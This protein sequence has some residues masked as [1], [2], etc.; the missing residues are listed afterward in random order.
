VIDFSLYLQQDYIDVKEVALRFSSVDA[1][2]LAV[3]LQRW[4]T[5]NGYKHVYRPVF[6]DGTVGEQFNSPSEIPDK[7]EIKDIT[8]GYQRIHGASL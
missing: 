1:V 8:V 3:A 6:E 2:E 5:E 7:P 4:T